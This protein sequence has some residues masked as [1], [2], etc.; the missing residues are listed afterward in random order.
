[1]H[2]GTIDSSDVTVEVADAVVTLQGTVPERYMKHAI[3]DLADTCLGVKDVDNRVRV[4]RPQTSE[5]ETSGT[6][7]MRSTSG[8][9][10]TA[11]AAS[12]S[13]TVSSNG[14]RSR[15]E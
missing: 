5:W 10:R 14:G 11:S 12:Q 1:M 4:E 2:A 13:S 15:K 3:E 7:S 6:D 9:G 8:V